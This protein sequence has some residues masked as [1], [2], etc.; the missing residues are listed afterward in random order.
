MFE[1]LRG[2]FEAC[3]IIRIHLQLKKKASHVVAY[4]KNK[5][6]GEV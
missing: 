2:C 3:R 5:Q 6:G 1:V 4:G